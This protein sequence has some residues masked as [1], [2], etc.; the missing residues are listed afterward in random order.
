LGGTAWWALWR[1][2]ALVWPCCC[3]PLYSSQSQAMPPRPATAAGQACPPASGAWRHLQQRRADS[4][5]SC[6]PAAPAESGLAGAGFWGRPTGLLSQWQHL[7]AIPLAGHRWCITHL[8][9]RGAGQPP[10]S[11]CCSSRVCVPPRLHGLP[12][13]V[14]AQHQLAGWQRAV[15]R[16]L[17]P[18]HHT[19]VPHRDQAYRQSSLAAM[20]L[21]LRTEL[22]LTLP[23]HAE[24]AGASLSWCCCSRAGVHARPQGLAGFSVHRLHVGGMFCG[25]K[26][27]RRK[28]ICM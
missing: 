20:W 17:V 5:L 28:G 12:E 10:P 3:C 2:T 1:R 22:S 16:L 11:C 27:L 23:W 8:L 6:P 4:R 24:L 21:L 26:C 25:P 18:L 15:A 19:C 9:G 14:P 7:P 13:T